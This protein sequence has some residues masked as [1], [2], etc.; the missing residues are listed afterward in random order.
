MARIYDICSL[1]FGIEDEKEI[2]ALVAKKTKD[3]EALIEECRARGYKHSAT[4]L[5][6][7]KP[8]LFTILS[9]RLRGKNLQPG[10][11]AFPHCQRKSRCQPMDDKRRPQCDQS[12]ARL[13]LQRV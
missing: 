8:D 2:D 5:E 7:A 4:S 10:R 6:N 3:V 13:L 1:R 9:N 12:E 11:E